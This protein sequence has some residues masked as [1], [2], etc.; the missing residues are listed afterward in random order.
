MYAKCSHFSFDYE[1]WE[2]IKGEKISAECEFMSHVCTSH[3]NLHTF[4]TFDKKVMRGN[5]SQWNS[6]V[7]IKFHKVQSFFW[8]I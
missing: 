5:F 7:V 4:L 1:D 6:L 8:I 3:L 2:S